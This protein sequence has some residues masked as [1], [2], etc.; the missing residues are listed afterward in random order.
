M[1]TLATC[2]PGRDAGVARFEDGVLVWC[3]LNCWPYKVLSD[4]LVIEIP[5]AH[6]KRKR[7][8]D[9]QDL[10]TLAIRAGRWIERI[11]HDSLTQ[12]FP[13]EWKGGVPKEMHNGLVLQALTPGERATFAFYCQKQKIPKGKLNNVVDAIGIGL[14][15]LGRIGRGG[16]PIP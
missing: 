4:R 7:K 15:D 3:G 6:E 13:S 5:N 11:P 14:E 12:K 8:V 2:D 1:S 9:P 10:I 16:R